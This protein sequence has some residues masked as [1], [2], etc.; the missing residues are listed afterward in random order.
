M[1]D[2]TLFVGIGVYFVSSLGG[3]SIVKFLNYHYGFTSWWSF[4][5]LSRSTWILSAV[6]HVILQRREHVTFMAS[7]RQLRLYLFIAVGLSLVE[8]V[9]SFS[10]STLPGS[11]Y[12]LLKGSDVG[13]S[14]IFSCLLLNKTYSVTKLI[15]AGLI[16]MGIGTV[17][18]LDVLSQNEA[19][20]NETDPTLVTKESSMSVSV[21]AVLCVGGASLNALCSVGTEAMLKQ[22]LQ[23]EQDRLLQSQQNAPSKLLLS[24]AYS[25]WTSFF[26]FA[27]LLVPAIMLSKSAAHRLDSSGTSASFLGGNST[28]KSPLLQQASTDDAFVTATTSVLVA[29]GI[30]LALLGISRFL[31]RLCK[32]FI[33]VYDSAVTFSIVQ[34]A[35]R[36]LGIY[37]VGILFREE[38][39]N[40]MV[41]GS[42]ISGVG[43]ALHSCSRR[44]QE[45]NS[46]NETVT[47]VR[48]RSYKKRSSNLSSSGAN[49]SYDDSEIELLK[50]TQSEEKGTHGVTDG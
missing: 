46:E 6:L 25:M 7:L 42:L 37:V 17:F 40:G 32:H 28:T 33:C 5:L 1:L 41:V 49:D 34:A 47:G 10:M 19:P 12:M 45:R 43:F 2:L 50:Q 23:E 16:M 9:N 18:A 13:W 27:L 24:N 21:A 20:G 15:A 39:G 3:V 36:W 8:A 44:Q 38:F 14:M 22:T 35:R 48:S 30:C 4:A 31:E 29:I 26:S 11:L